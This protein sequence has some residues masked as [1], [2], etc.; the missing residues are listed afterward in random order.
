VAWVVSFALI[1]AILA[2]AYTHRE[3]VMRAWPPSQRLYAA[4]GLH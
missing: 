2:S 4:F 3:S 1:G